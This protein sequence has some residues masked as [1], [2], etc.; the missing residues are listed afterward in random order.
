MWRGANSEERERVG[1]EEM[2]LASFHINNY[3][4]KGPLT[5]DVWACSSLGLRA[6]LGTG[7]PGH[8]PSWARAFL[9]TGLPGHG[10]SCTTLLTQAILA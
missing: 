8:G 9:G 5:H 1:V 7:L 2:T 10:P 6:F 4:T 3:S